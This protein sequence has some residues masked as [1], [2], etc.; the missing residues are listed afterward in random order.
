MPLL[1]AAA[2]NDDTADLEQV[3]AESA[4][5]RAEHAALARHSRAKA[6]AAKEKAGSHRWMSEH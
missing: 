4:E 2:S 5:T 3:L 6:E 1:V